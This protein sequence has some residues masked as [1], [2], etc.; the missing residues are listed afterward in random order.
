MDMET[1]MALVEEKYESLDK[2]M[3]SV[4]QKLDLLKD[5]MHDGQKSTIRTLYT[6]LAVFAGVIISAFGVIVS[7]IA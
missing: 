2:R 4:E 7:L 5:Q 6:S 3:D 1:R